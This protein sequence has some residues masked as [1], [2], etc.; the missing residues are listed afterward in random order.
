MNEI[1]PDDWSDKVEK[2]KNTLYEHFGRNGGLVARLNKTHPTDT[3]S[4]VSEL[5][6]KFF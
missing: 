6:I 1:L 2:Y 4:T 3:T 5:I